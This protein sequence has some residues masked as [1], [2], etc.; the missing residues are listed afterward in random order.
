MQAAVWQ[1]YSLIKR[2]YFNIDQC[3]YTTVHGH[4]WLYVQNDNKTLKSIDEATTHPLTNK[5]WYW[6]LR[7]L[8]TVLNI[9]HLMMK[10]KGIPYVPYF[11]F[12]QGEGPIP[13]FT[14][15]RRITIYVQYCIQKLLL[16]TGT[17]CHMIYSICT[18]LYWPAWTVK[19][20]LKW[21]SVVL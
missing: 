19:Y 21:D 15:L 17:V 11:C 4:G 18:T 7:I 9:F 2:L 1:A 3:T 6:Q 13:V 16:Y 20:L 8:Y 12:R 14:P 5:P 10:E